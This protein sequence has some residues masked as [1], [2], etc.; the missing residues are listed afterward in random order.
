[1]IAFD[2][3]QD[4]LSV[5]FVKNTRGGDV[6]LASFLGYFAIKH[7]STSIFFDPT[8]L[9]SMSSFVLDGF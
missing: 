5:L 3:I 9:I 7:Q 2:C 1:M 8:Q 4:I 6:R